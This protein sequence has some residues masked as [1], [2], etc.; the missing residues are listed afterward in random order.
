MPE[1]MPPQILLTAT[2]R[3]ICANVEINGDA[4]L[5][6]HLSDARCGATRHPVVVRVKL[7]HVVCD[8][9][10]R[11]RQPELQRC[12]SGVRPTPQQETQMYDDEAFEP[13]DETEQ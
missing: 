4:V 7:A 8:Q 13:L 9:R 3:R 2:G 10:L 6:H 5:Y 1:K 12:E 11:Y